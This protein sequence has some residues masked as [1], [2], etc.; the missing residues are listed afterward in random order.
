M[1]R[2]APDRR[3]RR[4]TKLFAEEERRERAGDLRLV[5]MP[6]GRARCDEVVPETRRDVP[7]CIV[8]IAEVGPD[9][10]PIERSPLVSVGSALR[11]ELRGDHVLGKRAPERARFGELAQ[12]C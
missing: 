8:S 9:L 11:I 1:V 7:E 10:V 3:S 6:G 12:R 4:E 2:R 5:E